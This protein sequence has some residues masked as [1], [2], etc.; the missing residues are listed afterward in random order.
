MK[1][2]GVNG[3]SPIS[4]QWQLNGTNVNA[5]AD[6]ANFTGAQS[7]V[8][9][10]ISAKA[11]DAGTYQLVL[12]NLY[13]TNYS[14]DAIVVIQAPTLVGQWLTNGTL[15]E[16][17]GFRAAGVHD[18]YD[19]AGTAAFYFTNDVP[20]GKAG[21][22]I[23]FQGGTG[24]AISNSSTS[25]RATYTNTFDNVINNAFTVSLWGRVSRQVGVRLCPSGVKARPTI[26]PTAAGRCARRVVALMRVG[27]FATST[28]AGLSLGT[29]ATL[30]MTWPP[31][32]PAMMATGTS[33]PALT[34]SQRA[35]AA[36]MWMA[37]FPP[38]RPTT[39]YDLAAFAHVCIGAKDTTPGNTFGQLLHQSGIYDVRIY[40][41]AL[42]AAA[43]LRLCMASFRQR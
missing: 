37:C 22:S 3:T 32:S 16:T 34:T 41:Y 6:S 11:A 43:I 20:L 21:K 9:T 24:I 36:C 14:S 25:G 18:G 40:N 5:L 10:I 8:L 30:W 29:R 33:I 12:T 15:A 38:R 39:S 1:A 42:T 31:H 4:Y 19:I 2:T 26:R 7:N 35:S 27:P 28:R 13:G 17:S 23:L